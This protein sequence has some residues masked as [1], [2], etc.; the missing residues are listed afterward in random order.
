MK[1]YLSA[2]Y[3]RMHELRTCATDL[4]S[5]G[6]EVTAQWLSGGTF[7]NTSANAELDLDDVARADMLINF[8]ED[9]VEHSPHPFASRGGRHVELGFALGLAK[10]IV[11]VGP[12][13][14]VF[15]QLDDV[16]QFDTWAAFLEELDNVDAELATMQEPQT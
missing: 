11:I 9:P 1:V 13:E 14:N 4:E 6:H 10:D 2:R 3:G 5:R 15:H 16:A 8:T 12:R 7:E